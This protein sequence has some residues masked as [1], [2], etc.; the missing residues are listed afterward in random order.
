M[1][2]KWLAGLA[3][4][5]MLF[6]TQMIGVQSNGFCAEKNVKVNTT[7][8]T[9]AGTKADQINEQ[10]STFDAHRSYVRF[11]FNDQEM[12]FAF[13]WILGSISNGGCEVGEAFATAGSIKDGDPVSWQTEWE[14]MA[15]RVEDRAAKSLAAG[16]KESARAGYLRASNYY[17][18]A[19]VSMWP[20]NPKFKPISQKLRY[21]M[22][23]A[24]K[25]HNPPVEYIEIPY[26]NTVLPGYYRKA[27][28]GGKKCKTLVMI[29]G[30]ET[31]AEDNYF[32]IAPQAFKHGYNF[33]TVD[34]PGQGM[35]PAEGR[36]FMADTEKPIK[37][38]IDYI[39][40]KPEVDREKLAIYGISNGGYFVPRAAMFE[41]RLKAVVVSSAVVDNYR[42][43]AQMPFA[44]DTQEQIN[45]WPAF[46]SS[47]TGAVA[48][49][50]GLN[51]KDVKGQ[52]EKTKGFSFDPSKIDMPFLDLVGEGEYENAE[53]QKQQKEC[54]D[55]LPNPHKK[56]IITP[57]SEG[58]SSHCIGENRSLMAQV[59]FDWLD[60][61]FEGK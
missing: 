15:V 12:D 30:G 45:K 28:N 13:Q 46:K 38:V 36:F 8:Q 10:K 16:H 34:I 33:I 5:G 24:G 52:V 59:V 54:M 25:L 43:F 37:A 61:L 7:K 19:L 22:K 31:F 53:T 40:D 44:K 41:K 21:C 47:V 27:D 60:E 20:D 29:G 39:Y 49:R 58:A 1:T 48:W 42:M 51:P 18:T 32:Y 11:H 6:C 23:E 57:A 14:K 35:M 9:A 26:E 3:I 56:M 17:R 55:A 2:N 50:W 4:S